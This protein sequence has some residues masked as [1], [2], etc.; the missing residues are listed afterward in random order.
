LAK[1]RQDIIGL[2]VLE[3]TGSSLLRLPEFV[4]ALLAAGGDS[5]KRWT[6]EHELSSP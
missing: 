2:S 1:D 4:D 6:C 5:V 3:Y